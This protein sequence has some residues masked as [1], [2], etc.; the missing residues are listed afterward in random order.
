LPRLASRRWFETGLALC[1]IELS[2]AMMQH[3]GSTGYSLEQTL[4]HRGTAMNLGWGK[5]NYIAGLLLICAPLL[6]R[7]MLLGS[8]RERV[9]PAIAFALVTAVQI[10]IASRA[11]ALLFV[12]GTMVQLLYATR[13]HRV[14]VAL[15]AV[16][17]LAAL[18]AS[19]IGMVLLARM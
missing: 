15:G 17:V 14:V 6:L 18:V 5:D 4:I 3:S 7:G 10:I 1:A 11:G 13:R 9:L 16:G 8:W 12:A 2:L 19:P